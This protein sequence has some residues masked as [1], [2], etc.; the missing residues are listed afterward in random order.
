[1][2][3]CAFAAWSGITS[4]GLWRVVRCGT[5]IAGSDGQDWVI[6]KKPLWR[7]Y[8]KVAAIVVVVGVGAAWLLAVGQFRWAGAVIIGAGLFDM[9][10]DTVRQRQQ[11]ARKIKVVCYS[12]RSRL[13]TN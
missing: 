13:M 2:Q 11:F 1:M 8:W 6:A 12:A 5:A 3:R 7:R 10:A 4:K 9:V